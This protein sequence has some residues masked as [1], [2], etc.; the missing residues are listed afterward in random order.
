[1]EVAEEMLAKAQ[2]VSAIGGIMKRPKLSHA[3]VAEILG[4]PQSKLSG[5][6]RGKFR[7]IS[8]TELTHCLATLG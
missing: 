8:E 7:G 4:I 2:L 6:L 3:R 1:M 5:V